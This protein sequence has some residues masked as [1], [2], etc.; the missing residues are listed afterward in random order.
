LLNSYT[1]NNT[2][3]ILMSQVRSIQFTLH[4]GD[5][6]EAARVQKRIF[7]E[8]LFKDEFP[9]KYWCMGQEYGEKGDTP[10]YQ[11]FAAFEKRASFKKLGHALGCHIEACKGS[12]QKNKEYCSKE[13]NEFWEYG[14]IPTEIKKF[15]A[16][17]AI[18]AARE[19]RLGDIELQAP[20]LYLRYRLQLERVHLECYQPSIEFKICYWLVGGPG[21]GKSRFA[22]AF[23]PGECFIKPPNKWVDG[24]NE[25]HKV[26]VINDLDHSNAAKLAYF[27]KIWA[28]LYPVLAEVK[29]GSVYLKHSYVFVT[30]NYRIDTLY[31]DPEL[32]AALH[33]RYKEIV[34][35]DHR[36][37]PI[38]EIEIKTPI[39]NNGLTHY[40]WI[41]QT[42]LND[43]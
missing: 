1:D 39:T 8:K 5:M 4:Q 18:V 30:S 38:G 25:M 14:T 34:V 41:N 11:G 10:H 17:E 33:R 37:T 13:K 9:T 21:T 28:D 32:R 20:E 42:T 15:G 2:N 35:L 16:G 6:D 24:Y 40:K 7:L 22:Y 3:I 23:I 27:L 43:I 19:D 12:I 31:S 29:G 26:L 36:E